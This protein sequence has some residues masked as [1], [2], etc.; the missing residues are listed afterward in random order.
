MKSSILLSV[1]ALA[2]AAA[3]AGCGPKSSTEVAA[4]P[5]TGAPIDSL[6]LAAGGS[7]SATY[8][9][10]ATQLPR[11]APIRVASSGVE[12]QPYRYIDDAYDLGDAFADSPPDYT[13][14]YNGVRPWVWRSQK[15]AYRVVEQT[16]DG[17]RDYYYHAGADQP[18]LVRDP[19]YAYGYD[20]GQLVVVYD[21][22]GRP[23]DRS[24]AGRDADLAASYLFR[25][26]QSA[27]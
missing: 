7:S 4:A 24:Y 2:L 3:L 18:F 9:P 10:A 12:R 8:A 14:D 16:P 26:R 19:S 25:A 27:A 20:N 6:P 13:V 21:T 23:I 15:G 11:G 22:A 5:A 1:S 17:E